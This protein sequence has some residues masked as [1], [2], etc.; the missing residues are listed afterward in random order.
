MYQY[1]LGVDL[2]H[3]RTYVVLMDSQGAICDQRRMTNAAMTD[4]VA[5]L[6]TNTFAVLEATGNWSYMYD[7]L[8]AKL[9]KVVLA[10]PK[11]VRAIAAARIK[12]D[13]IDATILAHL[14]RADLL[15]TAYAPPVEIRE[16]REVVRH[17]AKLVRERTR[18]KNR[19][20]RVLAQYNIHAPCSDLFGKQGRVFLIEVRDRLSTTSQ[21]LLEDYLYL[22]GILNERI[23]ALNQLIR[24]W[25]K[26]DPRA[27]LLMS[28]PGIGEY[29]AAIILAEIGDV[30]RFPGP[31]QLCSFAGLVPSTRS[32]DMRVHQGRITKEGSPWLRWIMINAAQRAPSA[33]PQLRQFFERTARRHSRKTARVA[34]ARKMLC[35]VFYLL[36]NNE[37]Y[38]EEDRPS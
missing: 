14:A 10:H 16:L 30:H 12:T 3:K 31:K 15:P 17:R 2:H 19:I 29:S 22:I 23:T 24:A 32:S 26:N 6:P 38:R 4:Y 7:V 28:M 33:S 11:R 35:I 13:R 27:A 21:L 9:D 20:H 25:A 1:Y 18:H 5:Q 36:R 34:L 8:A 37:P